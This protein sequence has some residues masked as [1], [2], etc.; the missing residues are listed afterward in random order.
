ME[1]I[2]RGKRKPS[3]PTNFVRDWGV[4]PALGGA[5]NACSVSDDGD[6]ENYASSNPN[7]TVPGFAFMP[8]E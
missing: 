1:R 2:S 8:N 4:S 6:L 3:S 5:T 7:G